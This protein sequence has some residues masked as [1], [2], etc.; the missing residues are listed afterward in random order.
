M[1]HGRVLV[2][3]NGIEGAWSSSNNNDETERDGFECVRRS[4]GTLRPGP[5]TPSL[6]D[7]DVTRF[8]ASLA[9]RHVQGKDAVSQV[10]LWLISKGKSTIQLVFRQGSLRLQFGTHFECVENLDSFHHLLSRTEDVRVCYPSAGSYTELVSSL[11]RT[12]STVFPNLKALLLVRRNP[13]DSYSDRVWLPDPSRSAATVHLLHYYLTELP[14]SSRSPSPDSEAEVDSEA[15]RVP[16]HPAL[17][18]LWV[19]VGSQEEII[20]LQET[21]AGRSALGFPIRC[22]VVHHCFEG[23]PAALARLHAL[24]VAVEELI[25][26]ETRADDVLSEGDWAVGLPDK[27]SLPATVRRDWPTV[28]YGDYEHGGARG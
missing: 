28:W 17:D 23:D 26:T 13:N 27:F 9:R 19:S 24:D 6:G 3:S 12:L 22:V 20:P 7:C 21:L 15:E 5:L 11:H 14:A 2:P 25:L 10:F 8:D 16:W 1:G 4:F 18:T